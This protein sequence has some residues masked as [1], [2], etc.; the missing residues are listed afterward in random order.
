[1]VAMDAATHDDAPLHGEIGVLAYDAVADRIQSH[2]CGRWYQK[3]ET[4]HLG[5]HGLTVPSYKEVYGL[6]MTTPL[7]TP[8]ITA[9]RRR[10]N[11]EH[12]G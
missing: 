4:S 8:R 2:A 10:K 1:M 7:E 5:Q 9:L 6:R 3:L 12:E 11:L